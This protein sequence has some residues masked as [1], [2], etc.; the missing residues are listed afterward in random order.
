MGASRGK[1]RI[2]T[3]KR[4]NGT[5]IQITDFLQFSEKFNL[6][7]ASPTHPPTLRARPTPHRDGDRAHS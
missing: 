6:L 1:T 4:L 2:F 7:Q 5:N 3:E